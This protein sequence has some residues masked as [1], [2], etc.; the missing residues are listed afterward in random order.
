[1][2]PEATA[3]PGE[4]VRLVDDAVKAWT[5][6][7][8]D[9]G[10]RNTL[11]YYR[12]LKQGTLDL[13]PGTGASDVAVDALL[14]SRTVRLSELFDGATLPGAARRARTVQAKAA[15]NFE[16]RGLHTLF[17]AWGMA[18]WTNPGSAAV[19]AAPVLLRQAHLAARGAAREDFDLSLPGEWE[20]NPT[21]LYLLKS[22]FHVDLAPEELLDLLD[23]QADPPDASGF[24]ERLT[25]ATGDVDGFALI[26]RVVVGNFSYAKLPM[27]LDLQTSAETL[28]AADII[29]AIAGDEDARAAIRA[30]H[31]NVSLDEPDRTPPADEFLV[32]D[33]DAS[34]SYAINAVV[35]GADLVVDGPPGTGKSQTIANLIATLAARGKRVLFVAEK[36]AAIDAV[37]D[38]L[39]RVKLGD[40]VLDLHDGAGSKRKLAQ[41]LAKSLTTAATL[42]RPDMAAAQEVLSRRRD[43]L[44]HRVAALHEARPPWG[45]SVYQTYAG[46]LGVPSDARTT[47]RLRGDALSHLDAA[48][49]RQASADLESFIGLGGLRLSGPTAAGASPWASAFAT[50]TI[51]TPDAA[52]QALAAASALATRT[53]PETASR[54]E[55]I[56]AECGLVPPGDLT[57]WAAVLTLL[58]GVAAT[59]RL[60]DDAIFDQPLAEMAADLAPAGRGGFARFRAGI[61]SGAYRRARRSALGLCRGAKPRAKELHAAMAAAATQAATWLQARNDGGRPR[62]PADLTGTEGAYQQLGLELRALGAWMGSSAL[63]SLDALR[64]DQQLRGLLADTATLFKLPELSRLRSR[65]IAL[66][67]EPALAEMGARNLSV[68]QALAF[69]ND[70]WL[71]SILETVSIGDPWIGGFDGQA[72]NRTVQEFRSGDR[73]HID[74]A[75][76]RV[77]RAVAENATRVRDAYPRESDVIEHQARLKRGHLPVRQLF[78]AAPHVLGALKPCWAMSPLVVSQLLPA[79]RCFDVVV[80]DEASQVTPA[81]AVGALM[82]AGQAVVAGDPHQ[83][84]PT[85]FFATSGGGEDDEETEQAEGDLALTRNMESIL[86]VIGAIL[87]PPKGTRTLGWHYRSKDERLIAFS[88]A[89]P[90]LYDWSLTT[91]PGVASSESLT[92]ELVPF[93]LGRAGQEDSVSDEVVRVV[94]L[95]SR[96]AHSRPEE[97]LGVIAMGIKHANRIDES[98]RRARVE[99]EALDAFLDGRASPQ[100]GKE[101]FFVKNLERVQG[102]ER[103]AIIL[104]IGYG[105]S[106]EGRLFYRFG[107][108]NQEGGER[109]LNVAITRARARMTVVSSFSSADMD[110]TRLKAEGARMLARYL[111]Y[112]E[113]GG[114]NL[115]Q[116]TK[117]KPELNPFERDVQ[118]Q[119]TKAGIP[120]IAQYGVSGYWID[121][122]AQHPSRPGRM[123]L[124][125][126]CDGASYHSSATARDRDRLRQEHLERLGWTFHRI[127][128][129][130]WFF[131]REAEI[132]RAVAAYQTAVVQAD[133]ALSAASPTAPPRPEPDVEVA[134]PAPTSRPQGPCPVSL[135][136]SAIT[137]YSQRDLVRLVGWI[138]S[139]TLLRTEEDLLE[140]AVR[141]LSFQRKGPRIVAAVTAAISASRRLP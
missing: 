92:H 128:S 138:E 66:G 89:Q 136:R 118:T 27:V 10:G 59:L 58:D 121:Y 97:S 26:P 75:A 46:L 8:I 94:E 71:N 54:L 37:V 139:D 91:F 131:H 62:L 84:P 11:L 25:K 53:L 9:L 104:S 86:D 68:D 22:Q 63:A 24:F 23:E 115:G 93:R 55:R 31:P 74:S 72:H 61:A 81:D 124:A 116:E 117:D 122:A 140:E 19:P 34:Q 90:S 65:L 120:L 67:L 21:L 4:R 77:M 100:A 30:R 40:L 32:L 33:A 69:L 108:I 87:P 3:A 70:L 82:R 85:S 14:G 52:Q 113:S 43:T 130:D 96:H 127:W 6:Q 51:P 105:K 1:M 101:P 18:T 60:F 110:L 123:V 5:G 45:V 44:V 133:Q 50:G 57:G 114:S 111:A 119:L 64:L 126:E 79:E 15:E 17:L 38:R 28:T 83:L 12:D 20:V 39:N 42:P 112:A 49:I 35:G 132:A 102:D 48:S 56:V 29:C 135:G 134:P 129:Q 7:L 76:V 36:R 16:E 137:E 78:Q 95:V 106:A 13:T 2:I 109:R 107:P 98:L 80:F 125:I 99:D 73:G 41:D 141:R 88:N 103:D 47:Q